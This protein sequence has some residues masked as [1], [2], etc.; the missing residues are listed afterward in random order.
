MFIRKNTQK[1]TSFSDPTQPF[2]SPLDTTQQ[3]QKQRTPNKN[4]INFNFILH[5]SAEKATMAQIEWEIVT[6]N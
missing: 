2:L 5:T 3:Q 6:Q 1:S 4:L